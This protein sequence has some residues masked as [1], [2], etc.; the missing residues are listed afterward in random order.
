[1]NTTTALSITKP[2]STPTSAHIPP[3]AQHRRLRPPALPTIK[4]SNNDNNNNTTT[5]TDDTGGSGSLQPVTPPD[6]VEIRFRRGS[7]R[8]SRQQNDGS[9]TGCRRRPNLRTGN[10]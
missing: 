6:T 5:T 1:M 4:S 3:S 10:P 9:P 8:K 7:R 2:F